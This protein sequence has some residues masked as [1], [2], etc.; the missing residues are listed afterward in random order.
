MW[1]SISLRPT[2]IWRH[3]VGGISPRPAGN[4]VRGRKEIDSIL[5]I[6]YRASLSLNLGY[7]WFWGGGAYNTLRDRDFAQAFVK[8]QF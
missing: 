4:F 7:T 1:P 2:V 3:D 8:Y 6:R 5:E